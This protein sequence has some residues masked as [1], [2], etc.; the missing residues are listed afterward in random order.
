VWRRTPI[1]ALVLLA[2]G[3]SRRAADGSLREAISSFRNGNAPRALELARDSE[4]RCRPRTPCYWSA[5]LLEAEVLMSDRQVPAAEAVLSE[6]F[7]ENGEFA[8]LAARRA[9]L[10]GDMQLA[11]GKPDAAEALYSKATRMADAAGAWDVALEVETSR[12]RLLFQFR[13]DADGANAVFHKVA[14]EGARRHEPYYEAI[15]LNGPGVIRL[16]QSHFDE[17]IPWFQRTMEAARRGGVQRLIVAAGHNLAICYSHLG[18]FDEAVKV[19]QEAIDLLGDTGL[20]PY[21]MD[22]RGEMGS[23]YL[24]Q[25]DYLKAIENYKKA[26][27]LA[28]TDEDAARWYR[29]LAAAY[30][31]IRDWNA[32]EQMNQKARPGSH[33]EDSRIWVERNAAEIAAGKGNFE[34]ACALY[35]KLI[36][37]ARD[38]PVLV[39]EAHAALGQLHAGR[40]NYAEANR[41]FAETTDII[42]H[43]VDKIA[44][45]SYR[46]SY[47]SLLI[48]FY[49]NYVRS[50]VKQGAFDR[51]LAVADS[52]RARILLQRLALK[53]PVGG[54]ATDYRKIARRRESTLLFYWIAPEQSY[55]WVITPAKVHPPIELP[56]AE[57]I[58]YWVDQ[59]RRFIEQQLG[60]PMKTP[61]E[62]A[63]HLYD[64]LIAPA[65]RL[66]PRNSRVILFPDDALYW[67]NF[68]TLPVYGNSPDQTPH[69][70][71]DD[72]R[73]EIA[74]SLTALNESRPAGGPKPDSLLM[75]GDPVPASPEF[76]KLAY[77]A[78]EIAAIGARFPAAEQKRFTG[79]QAV[80]GVYRAAG[81]ERYSVLHF[82]A[83]A[84]ANRESP[85]DSAI[86]LSPQGD[87]FKL[88]ARNIIDTPLHAGL[89]TISA[90]RSAGARSYSG[91]GLVGFAWAFLQAGAR[92]V[93]AGLWDVTDSSTP[94][95]MD[96]LYSRILA[97]MNPAD[98]LREAKL[99][100]IRSDI[101]Y[102]RPYYWG[103]FQIY[104]R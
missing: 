91:E 101:G 88:Y 5:R 79:V 98:A 57:Q 67:L 14:A 37:E 100:L 74:P 27:A 2:S 55:L 11:R 40:G 104:T 13:R 33:D 69:Y 47:F 81:P 21:R 32:A 86:I 63:R 83:H 64:A 41:E 95:I 62:A 65:G 99:T 58:R 43:N 61:N 30:A 70:W 89:V 22:L 45:Q 44:A 9:W 15:G 84:V 46:L 103:P 59:Y 35:R 42:D 49:Q 93:I 50:L 23:T 20:A 17:A 1:L 78:S 87:N 24:E 16:R 7:P 96:A 90:C 75:I 71:I 66:I 54:A 94:G 82:S 102:R 52:S 56:P 19:R 77:A 31:N 53:T 51:G 29:P 28:R 60:D 26:L 85:L 73:P 3:C 18:S 36:A 48:R 68:E 38:N 80:P 6:S 10:L 39:W 12:G 76:P 92:N 97:G 72:V 25:Q 4:R 34:E 8:A